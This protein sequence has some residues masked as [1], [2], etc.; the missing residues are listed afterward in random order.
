MCGDVDTLDASQLYFE[1]PWVWYGHFPSGSLNYG[2]S[3][4]KLGRFE[5]IKQFWQL[6]NHFPPIDSI[7]DGCV[8]YDRQP[9]VAYSLFRDGVD[10]EWEHPR[11]LIG[12]EWGCRETLCRERFHHLWKEY[13]LGAIGENIPHCVGVRAINKSNRN[14]CLH[15]VEIWMDKTDIPSIQA[16]RRSLT[17]LVPDSPRFVHMPHQEKQSQAFEYQKRRRTRNGSVVG[18]DLQAGD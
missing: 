13:V 7:H 3:Y 8:F 18:R 17:K 1:T 12:S 11:N 2:T 16:C 10:P 15:K 6:F 4:I 5:S 14:R 9:I